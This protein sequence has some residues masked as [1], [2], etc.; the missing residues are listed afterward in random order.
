MIDL[1]RS[2]RISAPLHEKLDH[3]RRD[4]FAGA[5]VRPEGDG[6]QPSSAKA[7][8]S[9]PASPILAG[10]ASTAIPALNPRESSTCPTTPLRCVAAKAGRRYRGQAGRECRLGAG[11]I[12]RDAAQGT[13]ACNR[14]SRT[15]DWIAAGAVGG[16]D[17][18]DPYQATTSPAPAAIGGRCSRFIGRRHRRF[19]ARSGFAA[20]STLLY[21]KSCNLPG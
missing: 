5:V 6:R 1:H 9:T 21:F 11:R 16:T 17:P 7:G 15:A 18:L 3:L 2:T 10:A 14:K 8:L 13:S 4:L 20:Q 19:I 12:G